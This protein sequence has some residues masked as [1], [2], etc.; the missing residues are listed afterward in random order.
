MP[1][2]LNRFDFFFL[3]KKNTQKSKICSHENHPNAWFS[4][5]FIDFHRFYS[6]FDESSHFATRAQCKMSI[7]WALSHT[8][9]WKFFLYAHQIIGGTWCRNF[10]SIRFFFLQKKITQMSEICS[11]ENHPKCLIFIDFHW[12]SLIFNEFAR[13]VH[14]ILG[15]KNDMSTKSALRKIFSQ[16]FFLHVYQITWR[17]RCQNFGSIGWFFRVEKKSTN[18]AKLQ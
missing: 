12:F 8:F 3:Q 1:N 11:H 2:I 16:R 13:F 18:G 9:T 7:K 4:L 10:E 14:R 5:I 15:I 6:L 17:A